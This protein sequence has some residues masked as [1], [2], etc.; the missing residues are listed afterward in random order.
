M[1]LQELVELLNK[2]K[3]VEDMVQRQHQPEQALVESLVERQH[4][5]EIQ[6]ALAHSSAP[7]IGAMLESLSED[8]AR[9][10]WEHMPAERE[11]EILWEISD[12]LR[13]VLAGDREIDFGDRHAQAHELIDGHLRHQ[14]IKSRKDLETLNPI[15]VDLLNCTKAERLYVGKHFGIELPDPADG[16][17][18]EVSARFHVEDGDVIHL[19]SNFLLDRHGKSA[20]VPVAFVLRKNILF[21][22]RDQELPVFR[23][24]KR[25]AG[26]QP[27]YVTDSI[28]VLLDLYG[29]DVECSAD[30]LET[31]YE[32]LGKVGSQVLREV[33]TDTEAA[34]TLGDIAEQED[35]N[36]RIR[37][38]ILDTHRALSFLMRRRLLS[39]TQLED[40]RQILRDIESLNSHTAFLFDKINFLMDATVGFVNINQNKRVN[41]LTALGV[42]FMPINV[43]AGIG[44]MSEFSMMTKDISWPVAYGSFIAVMGVVGYGT[45]Q[46]VR[47]VESRKI[48][49]KVQERTNLIESLW[50]KSTSIY[51]VF[52]SK[53]GAKKKHPTAGFDSAV[54]A[55]KKS[56]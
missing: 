15:W 14:N 56:I 7:E 47:Y 39:P 25:R 3:L 2:Q 48:A 8:H 20:S 41:Q 35:L 53:K 10:L 11:E 55:A 29:A 6:S 21:T 28:D 30:A 19:R 50:R 18:L 26:T 4:S 46:I 1:S 23:L 16:N 24:Q 13:Q 12:D 32:S 9:L 43:L 52:G 17:D 42:V 27:G 40:A 38:N 44:G 31:I 34:S 49:K 51:G 36:G 54:G 37:S 45:Y 5:K 22:I 33:M